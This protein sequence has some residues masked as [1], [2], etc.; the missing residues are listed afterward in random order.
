MKFK[1]RHSTTASTLIKRERLV[2]QAERNIRS[3]RT[4]YMRPCRLSCIH[5][6][7]LFDHWQESGGFS[8]NIIDNHCDCEYTFYGL[9][10]AGAI[11]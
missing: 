11:T 1:R 6:N 3:S 9:L 4:E 8:G 10:A 5:L 2:L 7:L